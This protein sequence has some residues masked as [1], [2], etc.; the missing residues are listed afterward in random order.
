MNERIPKHLRE[1][2]GET[3]RQ[4]KARKRKEFKK[5]IEAFDKFRRGCAYA[6]GYNKYCLPLEKALDG[7]RKAM[8]VEE[9]GR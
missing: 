9:W 4:W 2:H 1:I 5:V 6:N 7:W 8:S 3:G